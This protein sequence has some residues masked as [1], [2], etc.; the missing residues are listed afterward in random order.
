MPAS[1]A[2]FSSESNEHY[3]PTRILDMAVSVMGAID[4][5]PASD[6]GRR[7]R[8][9]QHFTM[10]DDG[11]NQP[12]HGRVFCNPPYGRSLSAWSAKVD[13]EF[14]NGHTSACILLVPARTDTKWFQPLH[15]VPVC[16]VKGRLKFIDQQ[17]REQGAAPFPSAVAYWG[18]DP[19]KFVEVF[20]HAGP[21]QVPI[22]SNNSAGKI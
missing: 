4:L 12:W 22:G 6:P 13:Q 10:S 18:S 14:A 21:V 19:E 9:A 16:Y 15:Q 2:M 1:K 11:L 20:K 8:A 5:D 7:V 3:T 17:G